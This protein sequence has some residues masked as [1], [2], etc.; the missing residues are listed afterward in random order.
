[1]KYISLIE[2][3]ICGFL[4]KKLD[5][6][7]YSKNIVFAVEPGRLQLCGIR[8]YTAFLYCCKL[9]SKLFRE[10]EV[11][12]LRLSGGSEEVKARVEVQLVSYFNDLREITFDSKYF[13]ADGKIVK[14]TVSDIST[15]SLKVLL[16]ST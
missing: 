4:T 11:R 10:R 2:R 12:V 14:H 3:E 9:A 5:R 8:Q 7:L 1:M 15:R 6:N 13:I 16:D